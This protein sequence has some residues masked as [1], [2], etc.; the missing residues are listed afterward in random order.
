MTLSV[1]GP[2]SFYSYKTN[3]VEPICPIINEYIVSTIW[4]PIHP[5]P[6]YPFINE[7]IGST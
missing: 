6:I 2:G 5:K 3:I 4:V 1:T 7:N